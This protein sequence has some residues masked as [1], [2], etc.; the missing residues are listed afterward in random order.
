M[1][2]DVI[3][4]PVLLPEAGTF[5]AASAESTAAG[6]ED[7]SAQAPVTNTDCSNLTDFQGSSVTADWESLDCG[8]AVWW[9]RTLLAA[10]GTQFYMWS[11]YLPNLEDQINRDDAA[12]RHV[13]LEGPLLRRSPGASVIGDC[14]NVTSVGVLPATATF[15]EQWDVYDCAEP[16]WWY[17]VTN[18]F[19]GQGYWWS[20]SRE[21]LEAETLGLQGGVI[22]RIEEGPVYH[23]PRES[24]TIQAAGPSAV[25]QNLPTE[26]RIAGHLGSFGGTFEEFYRD[27][28]GCTNGVWVAAAAIAELPT[29]TY[30]FGITEGELVQAADE[31]GWMLAA[32]TYLEPTVPR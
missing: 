17:R 13:V 23:A 24:G 4:G 10:T 32:P 21:A 2:R 11:R 14:P 25:P 27:Q 3:D 20:R 22:R 7:S 18:I 30:A 29:Y 28:L 31:N 26:C 1:L 16:V 9:F 12:G 6:L 8:E 5:P 15:G 19:G